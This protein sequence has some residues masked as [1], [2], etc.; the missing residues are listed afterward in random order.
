MFPYFISRHSGVGSV[1]ESSH[2]Q[3]VARHEDLEPLHRDTPQVRT[4][5]LEHAVSC[6]LEQL[7]GVFSSLEYQIL[8]FNPINVEILYYIDIDI[9]LCSDHT[10]VK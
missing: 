9:V 8:I 2:T 7:D 10:D 6:Q 1:V 4:T 5:P 3:T